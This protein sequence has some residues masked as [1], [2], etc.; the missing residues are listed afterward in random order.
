MARLGCVGLRLAACALAECPPPPETARARPPWSQPL[1][2]PL[3]R[4]G[5]G[6]CRAPRTAGA[7]LGSRARGDPGNP[8]ALESAGETSPPARTIL[9]PEAL[10]PWSNHRGG[11]GGSC[12]HRPRCPAGKSPDLTRPYEQLVAHVS[13]VVIPRFRP[14]HSSV[15]HGHAPPI[16]LHSGNRPLML[17]Y[18][19]ARPRGTRKNILAQKRTTKESAEAQRERLWRRE[20]LLGGQPGGHQARGGKNHHGR[21]PSQ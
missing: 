21:V 8:N 17:S 11:R 5:R 1:S 12:R 13:S 16:F 15:P 6:T 2:R 18:N 10:R 9:G 20:L 19:V 7:R 14:R 3:R 4:P